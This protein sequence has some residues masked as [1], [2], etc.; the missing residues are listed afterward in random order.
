MEKEKE[1]MLELLADRTLFGL[2]EAETAELENLF[3]KFPEFKADDSFEMAAAAIN[4]IHLQMEDS[5]PSHLHS[6]LESQAAEFFGATPKAREFTNLENR[7]SADSAESEIAGNIYE[8]PART[9]VWQ[10][11]GWAVAVAACVV[12]AIN[13][14]L[15]HS[16]P[17]TE[18]A[19]NSETVKTPEIIKTP[20][21]ELTAAQKREQL[22]AGAP[23]VIQTNWT[24]PNDKGKILGDVVWSNSEQKGY[25]RLHGLPVT[26]SGEE[27]YQLWIVDESRSEK[28]PLSGGVFNINEQGD[29]VI[30]I[31]AQLE[32]K[33]PKEFAITKEKSGGVVVSKPERTV[34]IAKI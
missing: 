27:T 17:Q 13:L 23:D 3:D 29:I 8:I 34:A 20:T 26:N 12:L 4:L 22:I 10:W 28:T 14:W 9:S 2:T 6:K 16:Q 25:I 32:V 18:I 7:Q 19:R 30:P 1:R 5:L 11:L 15:T 21:P 31:Q 24:S 33:K